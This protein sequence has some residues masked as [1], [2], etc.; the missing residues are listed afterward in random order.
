MSLTTREFDQVVQKLQ[1]KQR[2]GK[3]LFV[4][5]EHEGKQVVWTARSHGRG[6]L[7]NVERAI[8]SQLRVNERQMNELVHCSMTR[9]AYIDH[10]K[11]KG[12]IRSD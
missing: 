4:W 5:L 3:H 8:R 2:P 11:A 6:E 12:A 7:G 9:D 10:L 1:M